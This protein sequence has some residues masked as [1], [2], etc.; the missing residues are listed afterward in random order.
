MEKRNYNTT[1]SNDR[2]GPLVSTVTA[3]LATFTTPQYIDSSL[4]RIFSVFELESEKVFVFDDVDEDEKKILTYN[5][6]LEN[7]SRPDVSMVYH[8]ICIN[9]KKES[10]T[11]YTI[12]GLNMIVKSKTGS[13]DPKYK[14]D[15]QEYQNMFV[16]SDKTSN[17]NVE[18]LVCVNT[19][20][21]CVVEK[22]D[23][24]RRHRNERLV[25]KYERQSPA[26]DSYGNTEAGNRSNRVY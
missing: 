9:R 24:F 17:K 26:N 20:L 13:I 14:I 3:L 15:W 23:F 21:N 25:V 4:R 6:I 1:Y 8:T 5:I 11:L 22:Q 10:N 7:G 16:T 2:Q 18:K 19:R 12:N